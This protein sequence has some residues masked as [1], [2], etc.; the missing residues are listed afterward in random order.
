MNVDY[1]IIVDLTNNDRKHI[2]EVKQTDRSIRTIRFTILDR[3]KPIDM[4]EVVAASIKGIKPDE[5]IVYAAGEIEKDEEGNNKNVVL[6]TMSDHVTAVT[7]T[8]TCE[9]QLLINTGQIVQSFDFYIDVVNQ[10]YD[11]DDILSDSDLSGF[12]AYM[13]RTL[14]A[15]I[16]TEATKNAF[17]DTYGTI[18][19]VKE[20]LE[21]EI[22]EC[23]EF[24][25][26]IQ[27]M[28]DTGALTGPRGPQGE[29][30]AN[31][32]IVEGAQVIAFEI[33]DDE[34]VCYYEGEEPPEIEMN[35][36]GELVWNY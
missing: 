7:G 30:G 1:N 4:S 19:T 9:L 22:E 12:K 24:L 18:S 36:D 29:N 20:E 21:Q 14:N 28:L 31:G 34:L 3:N 27:H 26:E 2:I 11:E 6:Y 25:D 8:I 13:I 16:R 35:D 10:L 32:I 33:V 17:E 23:Q 15:A 5:T